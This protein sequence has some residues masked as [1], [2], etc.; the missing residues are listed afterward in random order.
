MKKIFKN[1]TL[2]LTLILLITIPA[3]ADSPI[4]LWVNGNYVNPDV[5]PVIENERTLVPV[6][7]V[8][9]NL[10]LNVEWIQE[11]QTAIISD[12]INRFEFRL[13]S[14]EVIKDGIITATLDVPAKAINGRTMIP[15]R[16][17]SELFGQTISWD[18]ENQT[19]AIGNGYNVESMPLG[20][21]NNITDNVAT[22][23]EII[24]VDPVNTSYVGNKNSNIFHHSWCKSV[25]VMKDK[26]KAPLNNRQEA[27][28]KGY[29]PCQICKP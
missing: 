28:D 16:A 3:K 29:R 21:V 24:S 7:F 8:S 9:E 6:R 12:D 27:I 20:I 4:K 26:N 15:I 17:V 25:L 23:E 2:L 18:Q 10:G 13:G 5:P 14:T 19:V 1:I 11:T 22:K